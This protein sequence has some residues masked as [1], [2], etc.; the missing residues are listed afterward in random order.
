M[1]ITARIEI[2]DDF[3]APGMIIISEIY[4]SIK[5]LIRAFYT[6]NIVKYLFELTFLICFTKLCN[7]YKCTPDSNYNRQV[8][9]YVKQ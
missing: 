8:T 1:S 4:F 3:S 7:Q 2:G 5:C 9:E 6:M